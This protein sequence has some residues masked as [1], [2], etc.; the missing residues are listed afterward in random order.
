VAVGVVLP[1]TRLAPWLGMTPLPPLFFAILVL[2][3]A[4]YL[5]LVEIAK[6]WFYRISGM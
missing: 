3:I 1:F 2:M 5:T 4:M 6:R